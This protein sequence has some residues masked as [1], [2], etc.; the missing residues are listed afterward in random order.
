MTKAFTA[1]DPA[2]PSDTTRRLFSE[3]LDLVTQPMIDEVMDGEPAAL[4][5]L[6]AVDEALRTQTEDRHRADALLETIS[7]L[8]E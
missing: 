1:P 8:V 6:R 7:S 5:R 2:P 4:A 3:C